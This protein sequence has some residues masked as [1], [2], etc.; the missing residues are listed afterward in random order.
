MLK[1]N[2]TTGYKIELTAGNHTWL[3]DEP[4]GVGDDAGPNPYD[5][6]LSS[7]A[8][9]TLMTVQMYA[10]RKNWPLESVAM[11]LFQQ[12]IHAEDCADCDTQGSA[13]VNLIEGRIT[14]KGALDEEQRTRLMEI[15]NR[16]PVHRTLKMETKIRLSE[17]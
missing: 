14:L 10:K 3:A 16:C 15:A 12:H 11:E 2:S 7:L 4:E 6:L 13:R 17:S 8:A 5:L 9:C 1:A